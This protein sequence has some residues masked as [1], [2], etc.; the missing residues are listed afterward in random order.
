MP[1]ELKRRVNSVFKKL[2]GH[3]DFKN[4]SLRRKN[5][6]NST[7]RIVH[8]IRIADT[9][10]SNN[11]EFCKI[12]IKGQAFLYHQIRKMIMI[13]I[14]HFQYHLPPYTIPQTFTDKQMDLI[15]APAN[16]LMLLRINF[17]NDFKNDYPLSKLIVLQNDQQ[18]Q[19]DSFK[20][21]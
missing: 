16:G 15:P 11:I 14:M 13:T 9:F 19:V 17:G 18:E 5:K 3:H 20:K 6:E 4:Y 8:D 21:V 2:T 10:I 7:L 1:D 12:Y